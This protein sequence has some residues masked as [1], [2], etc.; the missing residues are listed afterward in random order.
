MDPICTPAA[1]GL[2]YRAGPPRF[3]GP[4]CRLHSHPCTQA[5]DD[6][7]AVLETVTG[8]SKATDPYPVC[9]VHTPLS[10]W[11]RVNCVTPI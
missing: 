1:A 5:S 3:R 4:D 10:S 6:W 7:P 2:Q 9:A 8:H 11:Q